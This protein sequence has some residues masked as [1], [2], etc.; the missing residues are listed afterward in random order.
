MKDKIGLIGLGL[1]G[2]AMSER[3]LAGGFNVI[4]DQFQ[5]VIIVVICFN[6]LNAEMFP[7]S[8]HI[9]QEDAAH[10]LTEECGGLSGHDLIV[11]GP[12]NPQRFT[13]GDDGLFFRAVILPSHTTGLLD[14]NAAFGRICDVQGFEGGGLLEMDRNTPYIVSGFEL[15]HDLA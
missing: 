12:I 8:G 10:A 7:D 15:V 3:I 5:Y 1:V 13:V 6:E 11:L 9:R 14:K 2:T 4:G